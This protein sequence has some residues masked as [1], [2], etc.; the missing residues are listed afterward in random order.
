MK[1]ADGLILDGYGNPTNDPEVFY[2][3][4]GSILPFGGHKGFG[5]AF[6]IDIFQNVMIV[7][8]SNIEKSIFLS[9]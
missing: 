5:L 8:H 2:S 4:T 7:G 9:F 1:L 6:M 3:T